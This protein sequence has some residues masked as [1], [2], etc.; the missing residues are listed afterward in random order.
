[1]KNILTVI[2]TRPE[3]IKLAP[4][5]HAL[6]KCTIFKNKVCLTNQHTT[7]LDP[8]FLY[9]E[10]I[11]VH[12]Q[13][14]PAKHNA[15]LAEV[16]A[17]MLSALDRI[18]KKLKPDLLIVQGDTT[19]AFIAS[20][21]AFY[22]KIKV[23]HIEAGLRTYDLTS[24]WPEEAHRIFIDK[25]TNYY[26]AP[27]KAARNNLIKE[28]V[29]SKQIW[30]TGNTIIDALLELKPALDNHTTV[31][32]TIII[33]MHRRENWGEPLNNCCAAVKIIATQFPDIKIRFFLHPNPCA[34]STIRVILA[35]VKNVELL[36]AVS[37]REFIKHLQ[38]CLFIITDSG[39]IQE[40]ASF[41]GK[42]VIIT[43]T[44]TERAELLDAR[45]GILTD[46][47]TETLV[48]HCQRL[49]QDPVLLCNMSKAHFPYGKGNAS[50][51]IV[52]ILEK[53]L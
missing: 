50:E 26:F 25:M 49:L 7:L 36:P 32:N 33:T 35:N 17:H 23:A 11:K 40:E 9:L 29:N 12:Y 24:P 39:G 44:T 22:W 45:T 31:P 21:A 14:K 8:T 48:K 43:R 37:H 5:I 52:K 41:I 47:D 30:V 27:T 28:G 46:T 2:G 51:S 19:T 1:M 16:A 13:C 38:E 6:N 10:N 18:I 42:P 3:I 4:V 15:S 34:H 53:V 20:L